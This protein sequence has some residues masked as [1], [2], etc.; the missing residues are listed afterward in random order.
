[1]AKRVDEFERNLE[2]LKK[3]VAQLEQG[4]LPLESGVALFKEG[5][6]LAK[7]CSGQLKKARNEVKVAA[8][9]LIQEF[10]AFRAEEAGGRAPGEGE[11]GA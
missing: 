11:D 10:E 4:D 5:L 3:I 1:M 6:G 7:S 2:R 9:G 8:D